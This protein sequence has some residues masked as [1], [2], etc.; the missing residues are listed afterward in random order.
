M[1][2]TLLE[3]IEA[4][5]VAPDITPDMYDQDLTCDDQDWKQFLGSL[6]TESK[7]LST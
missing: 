7:L 3:E 5:F 4:N 1:K 2:D 6:T